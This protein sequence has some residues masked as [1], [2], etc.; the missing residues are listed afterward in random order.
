MPRRPVIKLILGV[1]IALASFGNLSFGWF[2]S[3]DYIKSTYPT[4]YDVLVSRTFETTLILMG[5]SL[6][7]TG[8][9]DLFKPRNGS[10]S[11]PAGSPVSARSTGN[12]SKAISA[13]RDV[14]FHEAPKMPE[15]AAPVM[16]QVKTLR[17]KP[18]LKYGGYK[19][20]CGVYQ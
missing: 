8:L 14:I 7:A 13:G 20:Y 16:R 4:L 10:A 1:V 6:S 5:L 2:V 19:K 11:A 17:D 18:N 9:Y 15:P 3:L 12:V